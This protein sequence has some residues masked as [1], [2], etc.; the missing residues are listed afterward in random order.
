VVV[1]SVY[2][3]SIGRRR[4]SMVV[5]EAR[6]SGMSWTMDRRLRVLLERGARY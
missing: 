5:P 3:T 1:V 6:G 2:V 4:S